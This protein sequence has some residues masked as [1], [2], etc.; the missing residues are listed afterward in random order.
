MLEK[1]LTTLT[2]QVDD[3]I[4]YRDRL[5][6]EI[7]QLREVNL[8]IAKKNRQ[9]AQRVNTLIERLKT[10]ETQDDTSA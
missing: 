9:A 3:L 5:Y 4:G 6:D 2:E 8:T 7:Q 1:V 10:L